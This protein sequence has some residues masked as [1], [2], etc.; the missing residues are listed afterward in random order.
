ME[1]LRLGWYLGQMEEEN[2][3]LQGMLQAA[4]LGQA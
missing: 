1:A 4:A 2:R 3:R